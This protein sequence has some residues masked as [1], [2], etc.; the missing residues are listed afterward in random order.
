[1]NMAYLA[2]AWIW[3]AMFHLD[4]RRKY[5]LGEDMFPQEHPGDPAD[6]EPAHWERN[7]MQAKGYF[8]K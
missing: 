2:Y 7:H 8:D 5:H 6:Y 3:N 1:M 4:G